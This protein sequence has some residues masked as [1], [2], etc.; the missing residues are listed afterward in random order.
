MDW[1]AVLYFCFLPWE[2]HVPAGGWG[3]RMGVFLQCWNEK[4]ML[5]G[6][7][8]CCVKSRAAQQ[9]YSK[10][11][12]CVVHKWDINLLLKA[13]ETLGLFVTASVRS[14]TIQQGTQLFKIDTVLGVVMT[15]AN[16]A[17]SGWWWASRACRQFGVRLEPYLPLPS[18]SSSV[19]PTL[20]I[21]KP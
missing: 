9:S 14:I 4:T 5:R 10:S 17:P 6:A 16:P 12:A 2:Q 1:S 21:T 8:H 13:T 20:I 3:W 11:A 19:S 7:E 18:L 15:I